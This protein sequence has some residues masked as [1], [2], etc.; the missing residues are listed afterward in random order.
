MELEE[1]TSA[2][3]MFRDLTVE[4]TPGGPPSAI[5]ESQ[6]IR[7]YP[8]QRTLLIP[9]SANRNSRIRVRTADAMRS[10]IHTMTV[11]LESSLNAYT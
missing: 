9:A 11:C 5:V 7:D 4:A 10:R 3:E 1:L 8:A 6:L 2:E